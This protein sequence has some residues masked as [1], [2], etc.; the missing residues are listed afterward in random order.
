MTWVEEGLSTISESLLALNRRRGEVDY[1]ISLLKRSGPQAD[2]TQ[3][4]GEIAGAS[5]LNITLH[6]DLCQQYTLTKMGVEQTQKSVI[7]NTK[8]V[9]RHAL[10]S[11]VEID[12]RVGLERRDLVWQ[13]PSTLTPH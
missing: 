9:S 5:S 7:L 2:M 8:S 12:L 6:L 10:A 3:L 13:H 1:V 4:A 11:R